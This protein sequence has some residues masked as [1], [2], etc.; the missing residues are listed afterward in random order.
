NMASS[1]NAPSSERS[2]S[3]PSKPESPADGK[4][5]STAGGNS[6]I[7]GS[8]N[9]GIVGEGAG[10]SSILGHDLTVG[11]A[12]IRATGLGAVTTAGASCSGK[13]RNL[14]PSRSAS[15]KT[16]RPRSSPCSTASTKASTSPSSCRRMGPASVAGVKA[17][18]ASSSSAA[19]NLNATWLKLDKPTMD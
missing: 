16:T 15:A 19:S 5:A 8:A 11:G 7:V 6:G 13:P 10:G 14:L 1:G 4:L 17:P 9:D 12:G 3:E 2:D 18:E